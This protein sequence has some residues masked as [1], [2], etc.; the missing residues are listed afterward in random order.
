MVE[1]TSTI[2]KN[3]ITFHNRDSGS[4]SFTSGGGRFYH[5]EIVKSRRHLGFKR[6]K[7]DEINVSL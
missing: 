1:Y 7:L 6:D 4:G 3:G 2:R 5:N